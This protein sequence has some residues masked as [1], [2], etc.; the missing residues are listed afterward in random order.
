MNP[1]TDQPG[2]V[3]AIIVLAPYLFYLG[4]KHNDQSLAVIG[5]VFFF[6]EIYWVSFAKPR[7]IH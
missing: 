6:Y 3:F 7:T 1:I 4:K 2:R 5:F